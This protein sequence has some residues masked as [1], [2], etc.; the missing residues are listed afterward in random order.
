MCATKASALLQWRCGAV[1]YLF[2]CPQSLFCRGWWNVNNAS[3][4]MHLLLMASTL[5]K[6]VLKNLSAKNNPPGIK[7]RFTCEEWKKKGMEKQR[8]SENMVLIRKRI[9]GKCW[10]LGNIYI[11]T[12]LQQCFCTF[13]IVILCF[14]DIYLS[15]PFL[16]IYH[17]NAMFFGHL[18]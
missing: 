2:R 4:Q 3:A 6:K 16:D 17:G 14:L 18:P 8:E 7:H 1:I 9:V 5:P 13:T 10:C 11:F 12:L 15:I